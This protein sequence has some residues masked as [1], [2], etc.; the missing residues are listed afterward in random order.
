MNEILQLSAL[1]LGFLVTLIMGVTELFNRLRARDFWVAGSIISSAV[2]GGLVGLYY[3]VD[4]IGG[5][6]AGLSAS[7]LLKGLSSFGNKSTAA[8]SRLLAKSPR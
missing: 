1:Q 3:G 7:G 2:I 6:T 4:I 5:V 8:P